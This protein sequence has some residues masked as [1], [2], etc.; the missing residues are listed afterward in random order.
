MLG[1]IAAIVNEPH[2]EAYEDSC[3]FFGFF[4]CVPDYAVA[5]ALLDAA[6][7]ALRQAG[8]RTMRGPTSPSLNYTSGLLV[9]GFD[10]SPSIMMPYNDPYYEDLLRRYGFYR[11]MTMHA[12]YGAWKHLNLDRL[13][14][15]AELV[16][17]RYPDVRMRPLSL[18]RYEE[19][20]LLLRSLYNESFEGGWGHVPM[21]REEFTLLAKEMR[22]VANPDLIFILEKG[23]RPVGFILSLP[24][25]NEVLGPRFRGR[26]FSTAT[27]HAALSTRRGSIKEF[28]TILLGL[29]PP[30]RRCG[31]DVVLINATVERGRRLGYT[32]SELSWV[33]DDNEVLK[34]ALTALGAVK[35]K[36]YAWL[37]KPL[38]TC[39][40]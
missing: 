19:E 36:E 38:D 30:F 1:R 13:S 8:L 3:G 22:P 31:F 16:R 12:F 20:M 23:E 24:N 11:V 18:E 7:A 9:S 6:S 17:S 5:E 33:M 29:L 35:D 14:R 39:T 28:R 34:N 27:L 21:S 25:L 26:Y 10:R 15:G 37:E 32:A 4:D 2:L 40:G